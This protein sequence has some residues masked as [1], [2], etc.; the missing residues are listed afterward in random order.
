MEDYF[1]VH[2]RGNN[3]IRRTEK[4]PLSSIKSIFIRKNNKVDIYL[5][6]GMVNFTNITWLQRPMLDLIR[7]KG[8]QIFDGQSE[9]GF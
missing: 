2:I 8:I 7:S 5:T 6:T 9:T 1:K 4:I 3:D